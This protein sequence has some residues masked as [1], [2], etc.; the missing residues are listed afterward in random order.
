MSSEFTLPF[1]CPK[2]SVILTYDVPRELTGLRLDVFVQRMI[3][4]LSRTKA[5][6]IV[7]ASAYHV[8]GSRRKPSDR[9]ESGQVVVLVRPRFEEPHTPQSFAVLYEDEAVLA[10][11]KPAGLPVHPSATYYKNTLTSLLKKA[12]GPTAP[13][14]AHR[15][16]RETSGVLICGCTSAD[17]RTLKMA[18]ERR[19]IKKSYLAIAQ[20]II[21]ED[22]G[23]I[24]VAVVP[25][26]VGSAG[27]HL[28]MAPSTDKTA[29][30]AR[31]YFQVRE[32]R[33]NHTLVAL[34]PSTGRQHQLRVHLAWL[35]HP[36]VGDKLYG[37]QGASVFMEYIETGMTPE[38]ALRAGHERH[39]L[40]AE[41]LEFVHP[42][43]N[44][45]VT[46]QAPLAGDLMSLW[47]SF[48]ASSECA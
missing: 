45:P 38:L 20:G 33:G 34:F 11:D 9:V 1:K 14:I 6:A 28:L 12:Y 17:E 22:E 39:A 10:L 30:A 3:P 35:G 4:R 26:H 31:T 37:A 44:L 5:Q 13:R 43:T 23:V 40:H 2:D 27:L 29:P 48:S 7:R 19:E 8:D 46:I 15:L 36:I 24:D 21:Q 16:D 41:T 42:R 47:D 32:R 18:F 25:A